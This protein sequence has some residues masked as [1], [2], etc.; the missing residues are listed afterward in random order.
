MPQ[1]VHNH[2]RKSAYRNDGERQEWR[3]DLGY[4]CYSKRCQQECV[5]TPTRFSIFLSAMLEQAYRDMGDVVYIKSRQNVDL[6][7]VAHFRAKTK[8]Y[9]CEIT[10]FCRRQC[11][12][13]CPFSRGDPDDCWCVCQCIIKVWLQDHHKNDRSDVP[14]ELYNDHGGGHQ[15]R[16][17]HTKPCAIM[18]VPRQYNSKKRSH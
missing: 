17:N 4:I 1:K 5:L 10:A 15:C 13:N 9:T 18:Y 3:E 14:T 8:I 6:F 16:R 2:D 12:T 11:T 7:T